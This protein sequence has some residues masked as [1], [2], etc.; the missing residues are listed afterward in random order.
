MT[1]NFGYSILFC[2]SIYTFPYYYVYFI[3]L[4]QLTL[5]AYC[6]T[7]NQTHYNLDREDEPIAYRQIFEEIY[8]DGDGEGHTEGGG[9]IAKLL[10]EGV[11]KSF[12]CVPGVEVERHETD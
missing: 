4:F 2:Y 9:N 12:A 5:A 11:S 10:P 6:H 8:R 7:H 3:I 1:L